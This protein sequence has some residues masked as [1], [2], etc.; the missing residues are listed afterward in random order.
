MAQQAIQ[1]DVLPVQ[2]TPLARPQPNNDEAIELHEFAPVQQDSHDR[3]QSLHYRSVAPGNVKREPSAI[4]SS[5]ESLIQPSQ[6]RE[7]RRRLTW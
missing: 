2:L 4:T 7:T 1:P 3:L 5:R 6:H